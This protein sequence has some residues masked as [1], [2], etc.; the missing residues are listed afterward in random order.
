[1]R[2]RRIE[3]GGRLLG[4]LTGE[5]VRILDFIDDLKHSTGEPID[6]SV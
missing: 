5:P 4:V 6:R 1:M 2:K 3:A